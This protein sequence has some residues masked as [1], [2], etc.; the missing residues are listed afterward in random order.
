MQPEIGTL[1]I[2]TFLLSEEIHTNYIKKADFISEI[3]LQS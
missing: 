1:D 3:G 2:Y